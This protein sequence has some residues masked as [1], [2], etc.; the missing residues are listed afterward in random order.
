M[1]ARARH[2][3]RVPPKRGGVTTLGPAGE[4]GPRACSS[5]DGGLP[6]AAEAWGLL[7]LRLLLLLLQGL[8]GLGPLGELDGE[9]LGLAVAGDL[10]LHA[11][12][13]LEGVHDRGQRRRVLDGLA[14]HRGDH[15]AGHQAAVGRR[16]VGGELADLRARTLRVA[17]GDAE[18]GVRDLAAAAQLVDDALDRVGRDREA[19]A[20]VA[21][22]AAAGA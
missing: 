4:A 14:A 18:V 22:L 13:G 8:R 3:G 10:D 2:D 17:G 7:L 6:T 21:R 5:H 11:V 1:P 15:V 20:D 9:G 12:A 19:D 16:A